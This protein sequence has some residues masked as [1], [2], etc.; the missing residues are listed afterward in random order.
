VELDCDSWPEKRGKSDQQQQ[1]EKFVVQFYNS[2]QISRNT[3]GK[4]D[5]CR[6]LDQKRLVLCNL[7]EASQRFKE[8]YLEEKIGMSNF[9]KPTTA[10]VYHSR[11]K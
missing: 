8:L 5:A 3:P 7:K 9:C 4:N 10:R 6:M 11:T 1:T 2:D